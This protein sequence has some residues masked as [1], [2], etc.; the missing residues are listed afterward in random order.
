MRSC[1]PKLAMA[2]ALVAVTASAPAL[3]QT[4]VTVT[5]SRGN[6]VVFPLG[7]RSFVDRVIRYAPEGTI[8]RTDATVPEAII[9]LP[10][11][12]AADHSGFVTMGCGGTLILAF[13][14]NALVDVDGPD[15]WI[16]EVGPDVEG[17]S[18]AVS[19]DGND[20][21][22]LG[23]VRG[24]TASIDLA[25]RGAP[26]A[27]YRYVRLVDDAVQCSGDW[28]GADLDAIGAIG[29]VARE[30]PPAPEPM[31]EPQDDGLVIPEEGAVQYED[32]RG[33]MVDFP[34]GLISFADAV[35][36]YQPGSSI[37]NANARNPEEGLHA[38][39]Y[40]SSGNSGY[41][42]LGC[43]GVVT[44][45]FDD[46]TL[47]NVPGP[48]LFIFE[49]GPDV[50][51]TAVEISVDGRNW[52]SV[53]A[54]EGSTSTID[55]APYAVPGEA[56]RYVRLIDDGIQCSGSTPG[57]DI[58]AVGAIGASARLVL[59]ASLLFDFDS[60]ALRP[61]ARR[62]VD[63]LAQAILSRQVQRVVVEGHTDAQGTD[64]YNL[65]LSAARARSVAEALMARGV[66]SGVMEMRGHG[67]SRPVATNDTDAGRQQNRRV[68]VLL[69]GAEAQ[70]AP[71][72]A[73]QPDLNDK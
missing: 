13:D 4:P 8:R 25:G 54:V 22:D 5:D 42:T 63:R 19:A 39:D 73:P 10:D 52:L 64:A 3:A 34:A 16:F 24:A 2:T 68:E 69:I 29:S 49:I 28:P 9:G 12:V 17:T 1:L 47:I 58:D 21:L 43:G 44:Y 7:E 40:S 27:Q 45:R 72:S 56:Y 50:E 71:Q 37:G 57:A 62:A 36:D 30:E 48:D 55:I 38:P 53:G 11:Y 66:S 46:N 35:V 41:V 14:D 20:W 15:L 59:D 65:D 60:D 18:V 33:N 70:L 32:T 67:E 51:G 31:P 61:E 26:G 6:D 23:E